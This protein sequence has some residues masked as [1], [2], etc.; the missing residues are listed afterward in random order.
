MRT[1][2]THVIMTVPAA[3]TS[4]P[5]TEIQ[6]LA[7]RLGARL[8]C[9]ATSV[10][11]CDER[12]SM[13]RDALTRAARGGAHRIVVTPYPAAWSARAQSG[14][15]AQAAA[16]AESHPYMQVHLATPLEPSQALEEALLERTRAALA[17]PCIDVFAEPEPRVFTVADPS[18]VHASGTRTCAEGGTRGRWPCPDTG[19]AA[20]AATLRD[21]DADA[22]DGPAPRL[23][24]C[25]ACVGLCRVTLDPW[26][27]GRHTLGPGHA[28]TLLAMRWGA[29]D[30]PAGARF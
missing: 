1:S 20:F 24:A 23:D 7:A 30:G 8:G 2:P 16:F 6:A 26:A 14:L 27:G 11:W 3:P 13:L 12:C 21:V 29:G 10:A 17:G 22:A 18:A 5:P 15:R 9:A 4:A 25:M 28:A 19:V